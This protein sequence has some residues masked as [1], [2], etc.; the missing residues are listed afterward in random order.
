MPRLA[1]VSLG[2]GP[3]DAFPQDCTD[4]ASLATLDSRVPYRTGCAEE[5]GDSMGD[6][7]GDFLGDA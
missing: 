6:S 3:L 4:G 2:Y 7:V 1:T 5:V